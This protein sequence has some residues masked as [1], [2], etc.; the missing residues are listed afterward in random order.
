M[1]PVAVV[2]EMKSGEA[3]IK[4]LADAA[5]GAAAAEISEEGSRA[6]GTSEPNA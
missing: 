6:D 5:A 4:R 1:V 2:F 3:Q